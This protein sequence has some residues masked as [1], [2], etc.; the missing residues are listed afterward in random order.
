M[1]NHNK[2]NKFQ[3]LSTP[4]H[5]FYKE[6]DFISINGATPRRYFYDK[7]CRS[8]V[9]GRTSEMDR[10]SNPYT[11]WTKYTN[12][13]LL[14]PGLVPQT[15]PTNRYYNS[16]SYNNLDG[17]LN[18]SKKKNRKKVI[19]N[20]TKSSSELLHNNLKVEN[21]LYNNNLRNQLMQ[22]KYLIRE[23]QNLQNN[24]LL[25]NNLLNDSLLN[26]IRFYQSISPE[27]YYSSPTKYTRDYFGSTLYNNNNSNTTTIERQEKL[28]TSEYW[29]PKKNLPYAQGYGRQV[30]QKSTPYE[31]NPE[32]WWKYYPNLPFNY[33]NKSFL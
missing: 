30:F 33:Y 28:V 13:R 26:N 9:F 32:E 24:N 31:T 11:A 21:S 4:E 2:K 20:E 6:Y 25:N 3:Q 27:F 17:N 16:I 10:W 15:Q 7:N 12:S 8:D 29:I 19:S 22:K 23:L 14:P 5:I 18:T 1:G